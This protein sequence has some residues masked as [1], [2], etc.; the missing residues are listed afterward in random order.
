MSPPTSAARHSQPDAQSAFEPASG[1]PRPGKQQ[2]AFAALQEETMRISGLIMFTAALA[3]ASPAR[4]D[5]RI[6]LAAPLTG[7]NA[8]FGE[9]VRLGAEMAVADLNAAG[10]VGGERVAMRMED[11]ACDPR[12]AVDVANRIAADEVVFVL[13]HVCSGASIAASKVYEEEGI[14]MITPASTSPALTEE[15]SGLVFRVCGRDDRQGEVAGDWIAASIPTGRVAVIH[16]GSAYGKGLADAVRRTLNDRG[17]KEVLY[18][19]ITAGEQDFSALAVR[20]KQARVDLVYFGG[21]YKEAGMIVR[22][23]RQTG[24]EAPLMAGDGL[25]SEQFWAITG[26]AGAGTLFTFSPDARR[27]PAAT[28]VVARFR[29]AGHEPEGY[30]LYGYAAVQAWG[31]AVHA[32]ASVRPDKVAT[33]LRSG[34]YRTVLGDLTFDAKGDVSSP[35]YVVY[36]WRNGDYDYLVR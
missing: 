22:Q 6:A 14:L 5:I 19:G 30:S 28:E 2:R 34:Q 16:D 9:Q 1:R 36:S 11:D 21:Y 3:A 35:G 8:A 24:L 25:G 15:S 13:G 26:E 12:Q 10:G 31:Q 7:A 29:E 33:A 18:Q 20:L 27:N 23:M 32:A 17:V 4:A